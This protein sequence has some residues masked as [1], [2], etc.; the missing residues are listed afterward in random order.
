MQDPTKLRK[1]DLK[2]EI[3]PTALVSPWAKI[4]VGVRIGPY[5]IIGDHVQLGDGCEVGPRVLIDGRTT[6]GRDNVFHHGATIGTP[7]PHRP[8]PAMEPQ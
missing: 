4:G 2:T 1:I 3:H 5:A 8:I 7:P 6:I